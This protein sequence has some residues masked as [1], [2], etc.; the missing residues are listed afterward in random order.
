MKTSEQLAEEVLQKITQKNARRA[1]RKS[2][3]Q[4]CAVALLFVCAVLPASI[5]FNRTETYDRNQPLAKSYDVE[6]SS[7]NE[8]DAKGDSSIKPE[9]FLGFENTRYTDSL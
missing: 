9:Q 2:I 6:D 4:K 8:K 1:K 3:T 5:F 7:Q